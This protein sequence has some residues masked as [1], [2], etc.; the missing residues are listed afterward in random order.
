VP[1]LARGSREKDLIHKKTAGEELSLLIQ[2]A[3]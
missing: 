3:H 2:P 1:H